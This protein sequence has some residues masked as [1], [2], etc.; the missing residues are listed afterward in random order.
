MF[1]GS[2]LTLFCTVLL[3]QR[4]SSAFFVRPFPSSHRHACFF[5]GRPRRHLLWESYR[6]HHPILRKVQ[7]VRVRTLQQAIQ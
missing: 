3:A 1:P 5:F 4:S 6:G 7:E 2:I